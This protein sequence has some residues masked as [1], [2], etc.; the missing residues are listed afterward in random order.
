MRPNGERALKQLMLTADMIEH[1]VKHDTQSSIMGRLDE[2]IE[3]AFITE[4]LVDLK[5]IDRV[6]AMCGRSKDRT[7]QDA[8]D[9]EIHRIIQP[10]DKMAETMHDARTSGSLAFGA[11]KAKR[12]DL[13]PDRMLDPVSQALLQRMFTLQAD[14]HLSRTAGQ[15]RRR[16]AGPRSK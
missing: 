8:G 5:M 1:A 11:D 15:W 2:R 16:P 4:P 14:R 10:P 7:E 13:P 6:V 12:I 3:I 9:T